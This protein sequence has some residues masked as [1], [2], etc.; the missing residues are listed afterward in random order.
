MPDSSGL[1]AGFLGRNSKLY[2]SLD[3]GATWDQ[4]LET[5]NIEFGDPSVE[6]VDRTHHNS[7][8]RRREN[9]LGY[10]EDGNMSVTCNALDSLLDATGAAQQKAI[11]EKQGTHDALQKFKLTVEND[12]AAV[13]RT[14]EFYGDIETAEYGP[15]SGGAGVDFRFTVLRNGA[16]TVS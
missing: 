8:N 13:H 4:V 9:R 14:W 16:T 3:D 12:A 5:V 10:V 6:R 2:W 7:P 15:F 1:T 11:Y